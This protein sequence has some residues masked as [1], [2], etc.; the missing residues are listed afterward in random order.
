MKA[1]TNFITAIA[2]DQEHDAAIHQL[3]LW[4]K[5]NE[6]NKNE[7]KIEAL[8][9]AVTQYEEAQGFT[10]A[11]PATIAGILEVEMY[12][13]RLNQRALAATLDITETRLSEIL[14]GKREVN[15]DLARKL[16]QKLNVNPEALLTLPSHVK[17]LQGAA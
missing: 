9:A 7:A 10:P 3:L 14:K 6:G 13:R 17:Y 1:E 12:K 15:L 11:P 8:A 4:E 16:Y 2:N 5:D